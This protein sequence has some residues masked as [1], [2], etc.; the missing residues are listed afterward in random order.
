M[1]VNRVLQSEML[2]DFCLVF[3]YASL[4]W[5]FCFLDILF[6]IYHSVHPIVLARDD[7][8][9][10][11]W[12]HKIEVINVVIWLIYLLPKGEK[13]GFE[14]CSNPSQK[15]FTPNLAEHVKLLELLLVN[16]NT[17]IQLQVQGQRL[18]KLV[19]L[20]PILLLIK[21]Q[22]SSNLK[23]QPFGYATVYF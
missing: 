23:I 12:G 1:V 14:N 9:S 22:G 21:I 2:E 17:Q 15:V 7:K 16:L 20:L 18:G 5:L 19:Q 11:A 13:L 3:F 10:F 4:F 8:C 6:R